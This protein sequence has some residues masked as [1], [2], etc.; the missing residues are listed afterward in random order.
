VRAEIVHAPA[1]QGSPAR[2]ALVRIAHS[3]ADAAIVEFARVKR[4]SFESARK[5]IGLAESEVALPRKIRN[6]GGN[7]G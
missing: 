1:A 6:P 7:G 4:R 3:D 5:V 2:A